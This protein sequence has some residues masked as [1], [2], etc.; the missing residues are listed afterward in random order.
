LLP[1]TLLA[2]V[3]LGLF[4]ASIQPDTFALLSH[5]TLPALAQVFS[6]ESVVAT[7]W[8]HYLV[9]DLFVGRW[10][11]WEGQRTG[12]WTIHSLVLCLVAGPL[13][14]FSHILTASIGERFHLGDRP[15]S[16]AA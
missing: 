11:Y 9:M 4:A 2:L 14:V 1:I 10:I 3:Y 5:P 7:G 12:I 16:K 15:S 6:I 8:V 13:G